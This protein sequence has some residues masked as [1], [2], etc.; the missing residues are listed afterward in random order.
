MDDACTGMAGD[1]TSAVLPTGWVDIAAMAT[2]NTTPSIV[3]IA[4]QA[5]PAVRVAF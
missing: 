3:P 5:R 1:C 2:P 4:A